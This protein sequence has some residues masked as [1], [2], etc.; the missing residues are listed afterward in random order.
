MKLAEEFH[1]WKANVTT[2]AGLPDGIFTNQK[3]PIWLNFGGS[4]NGQFW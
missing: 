1:E 4:C 2:R 3:I